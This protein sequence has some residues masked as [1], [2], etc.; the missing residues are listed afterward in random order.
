MGIDEDFCM[1]PVADNVPGNTRLPTEGGICTSSCAE[2]YN[3]VII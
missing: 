3:I 1:V 2:E